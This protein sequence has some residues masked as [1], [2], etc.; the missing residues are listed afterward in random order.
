M[1]KTSFLKKIF[2]KKTTDYSFTIMFFLIFSMFIVF[3]IRPSLTTAASLKKEQEDLRKID[4]LYENKIMSI[5]QVQDLME[6]NRDQFPLL[7]QA[8]SD[9]P[10][11]N[12]IIEDIKSTG[13]R[14]SFTVKKANIGEVNLTTA[15]KKSLQR[16]Q[17]N[18]EGTSTFDNFLKFTQDLFNQRRLKTIQKM[19]IS[20]DKDSSASGQLRII[21]NIEGYYL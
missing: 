20:R 4:S 2:T 13:D 14:N 21:M 6:Q 11:I 16:L 9:L 5:T 18:V 15:D 12:K 17:I 7:S 8:V 1:N 19:S 3:A 10:A